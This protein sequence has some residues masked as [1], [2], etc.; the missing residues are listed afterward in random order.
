MN[1]IA[2]MNNEIYAKMPNVLFSI[3]NDKNNYTYE[4]SILNV[5]DQIEI[6]DYYLKI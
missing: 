6:I 1:E 3:K 2:S 5:I 4:G